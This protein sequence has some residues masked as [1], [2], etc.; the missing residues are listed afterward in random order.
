MATNGIA[1]SV[2][3]NFSSLTYKEL[4][5]VGPVSYFNPITAKGATYDAPGGGRGYYRPAS[6]VSLWATAPFLHNNSMGVYLDDP[7]V[8]GRMVQFLDATRRMLWSAKR[9]SRSLVL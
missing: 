5:A 3:D 9:A 1:G 6:Q 7:S 2:W 8:K 4:P